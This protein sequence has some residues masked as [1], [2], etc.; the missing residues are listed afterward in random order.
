MAS[1]GEDEGTRPRFQSAREPTPD[2]RLGWATYP[3][4]ALMTGTPVRDTYCVNSATG[5]WVLF[6]CLLYLN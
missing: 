3:W 6:I 4:R 1:Q 5:A 2:A